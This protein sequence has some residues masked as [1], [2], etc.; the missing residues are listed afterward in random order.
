MSRAF[1]HI[2]KYKKNFD[3]N[4]IL[5]EKLFNYSD[6]SFF[7]SAGG[8]PDTCIE[9][10][11]NNSKTG[12]IVLGLDISSQNGELKFLNSES[13]N[14][15]HQNFNPS[16]IDGHFVIIKWEEKQINVYTDLLG[17]RDIYLY[18]NP[19][20]IYLSTNP[21]LLKNFRTL[22]LD[23]SV[24]GSRWL[25]FNQIS[26]HSIIKGIE[27]IS[28]GTRLII[29][30]NDLSI[31]KIQ[32]DFIPKSDVSSDIKS[33]DEKLS[34]LILSPLKQNKKLSLSLSGGM[35]SRVLL[36]YLL[37]SNNNNWFCHTFGSTDNP[38][39]IVTEQI[40][41]D[42]NLRHDF[43]NTEINEPDKIIAELKEYLSFTFACNPAS[44]I[45]QLMNYKSIQS[46]QDVIIDGGFGEIWRR[47]FLNKLFYF[48]KNAIQNVNIP[49]IIK[50]MSL[51]KADIFLDNVKQIMYQGTC[52]QIED[53]MNKLPYVKEIG[54][55][56]WLDLFAIKTRLVNLYSHEQ[57]RLDQS[58]VCYMPF[59]QLSLMKNL[60]SVDVNIRK[61]SK[62]SRKLIAKHQSSLAKYPLAKNDFTYPFN[63]SPLR[64]ILTGKIKKKIGSKFKDYS[65]I[66]FLNK[67]SEYI[68]DTINSKSV[69]EY[70]YYNYENI[71][72][73][74]EQFRN[75]PNEYHRE[76]DWFLSFEIFKE[77]L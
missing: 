58:H 74:G 19:E 69:R 47:Q 22:E 21:L 4:Q 27:R 49:E 52:E 16:E 5:V 50:Y 7:L 35:D 41:A 37:D 8:N 75:N 73:I 56:N 42:Y 57:T 36:S 67:I 17:L 15:I 31:E 9:G 55:A 62:L 32:A 66:N 40:V 23:F 28:S 61:D 29:N 43:I 48:G 71:C 6:D 53:I 44:E 70:P 2:S 77:L 1:V 63:S 38:D 20:D 13:W 18:R 68:L 76:L 10:S 3:Y 39:K 46:K 51:P 65:K 14:E 30:R 59:A 72:K 12:F 60:F 26:P 45:I 34:Q 25:L 11:Q 33:I 64:L 54:L 24:F